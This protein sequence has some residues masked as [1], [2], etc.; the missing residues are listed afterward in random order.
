MDG[1]CGRQRIEPLLE[2]LDRDVQGLIEQARQGWPLLRIDLHDALSPNGFYELFLQSGVQQQP[3]LLPVPANRSRRYAARLG[4]LL[5]SEA[6]K[7]PH[8]DDLDQLGIQGRE[9]L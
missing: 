6:G 4:D 9:L 5:D 8:L 7:V 3:R 1:V 2:S